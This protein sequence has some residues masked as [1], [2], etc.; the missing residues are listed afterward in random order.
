MASYKELL[1]QREALEKR[2]NEARANELADAIGQV[3]SLVTEFG[4][5]ESD[6]FSK[7]AGTGSKSKGTTVA[8][9]YRDPATGATWT[10][11]GKP[12]RWIADKDRTQFAI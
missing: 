9:K 12:P 7:K 4:L 6:V 2:I 11:R 8:P 10:G 3:R 1:S 5:Q